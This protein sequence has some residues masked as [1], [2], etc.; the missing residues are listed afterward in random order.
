M[1]ENPKAFIT[2]LLWKHNN[3]QE[4]KLEYGHNIKDEDIY[5]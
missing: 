4:K 1:L 3:G 5:I 2:K